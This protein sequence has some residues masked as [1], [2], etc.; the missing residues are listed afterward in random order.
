MRPW[1]RLPV[2]RQAASEFTPPWESHSEPCRR[3][4]RPVACL[5]VHVF[6]GPQ[7]GG[8]ETSH[9]L[10]QLRLAGAHLGAKGLF[11]RRQLL[12]PGRA[13]PI[14]AG[15]RHTYVTGA[16]SQQRAFCQEYGKTAHW[17]RHKTQRDT[18]WGISD[19][20]CGEAKPWSGGEGRTG[21]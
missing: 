10:Q 11:W 14:G 18:G 5:R 16:S 9:A 6:Q 7:P 1:R 8:S 3:L 19:G 17:G 13:H 21:E 12:R 20:A 4:L 15:P 2:S